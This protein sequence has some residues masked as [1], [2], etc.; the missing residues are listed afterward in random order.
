MNTLTPKQDLEQRLRDAGYK[1]HELDDTTIDDEGG[2]YV[3]NDSYYLEEPGEQ[4]FLVVSVP[5][6]GKLDPLIRQ[7]WTTVREMDDF[8][9]LSYTSNYSTIAIPGRPK[10]QRVDIAVLEVSSNVRL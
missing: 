8:E 2:L 3:L 7:V 6:F 10:M 5:E 9:P 1:V 4:L